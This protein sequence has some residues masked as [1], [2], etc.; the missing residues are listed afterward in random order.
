MSSDFGFLMYLIRDA[1]YR[2]DSGNALPPTR[3]AGNFFV[4]FAVSSIISTA[5]SLGK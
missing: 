5:L 1:A 4:R 3:V 2:A